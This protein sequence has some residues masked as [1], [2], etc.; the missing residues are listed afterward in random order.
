MRTVRIGSAMLPDDQEKLALQIRR[1]VVSL[2]VGVT[3]VLTGIGLGTRG[4]YG[5]FIIVLA[6]GILT[7]RLFVPPGPFPYSFGIIIAVSVTVYTLVA[8]GILWLW[9]ELWE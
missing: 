9:D 7:L 4:I 6:P 8:Y 3:L 2:T 1:I 5:W